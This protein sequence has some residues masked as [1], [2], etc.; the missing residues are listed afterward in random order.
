[1]T[2]P[3]EDASFLPPPPRD[4]TELAEVLNRGR[5]SSRLVLVLLVVLVLVVV[6]VLD[7]GV[8]A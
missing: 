6:L 5:L 8:L 4:S 2:R 7:W 1:M 3:E